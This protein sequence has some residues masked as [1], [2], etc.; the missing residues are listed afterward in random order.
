M[1]IWGICDKL[2]NRSVFVPVDFAAT[3]RRL[4][5]NNH[6]KI[7]IWGNPRRQEIE[8]TANFGVIMPKG[9][10]ALVLPIVKQQ[11]KEVNHKNAFSE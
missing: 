1:T 4:Q 7:L 11:D 8:I 10:L 6:Q 3:P 9:V 5:W 2:P